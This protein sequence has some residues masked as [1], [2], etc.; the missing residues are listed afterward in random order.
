MMST[1][2]ETHEA[3]ARREYVTTVRRLLRE[4]FEL[5]TA[6]VEKQNDVWKQWVNLQANDRSNLKRLAREEVDDVFKARALA[7]TM[8]PRSRWFPFFWTGEKIPFTHDLCLWDEE[9]FANMSS[10]VAEFAAKLL[11]FNLDILGTAPESDIEVWCALKNYPAL[12]CPLITVLDASNP[13]ATRLF[14]LYPIDESRFGTFMKRDVA[15]SWKVRADER[16]REYVLKNLSGIPI[17]DSRMLTFYVYTLEQR[18]VSES[19]SYSTDLLASQLEFVLTLEGVHTLQLFNHTVVGHLLTTIG[20]AQF[21]HLRHRL[22]RHVV[23]SESLTLSRLNPHMRTA[24]DMILQEFGAEDVELGKRLRELIAEA[25]A[26]E[27]AWQAQIATSP[28]ESALA[29]ILAQM[30]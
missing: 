26:E 11:A 7:L 18:A 3:R 13:I 30:R 25:D 2:A 6:D 29:A 23:F 5:T 9:V 20:N 17:E 10:R 28:K 12:V 24:V 8:T 1:F 4:T 15:E 22:A 16:M 27:V 14:E 19:P 21:R